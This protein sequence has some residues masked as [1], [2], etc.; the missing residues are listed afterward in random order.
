M[1]EIENFYSF[2]ADDFRAKAYH[3]TQKPY[4]QDLVIKN[5]LSANIYLPYNLL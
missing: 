4:R 5:K 1:V 3:V 2:S